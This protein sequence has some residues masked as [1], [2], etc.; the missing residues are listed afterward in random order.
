MT[1]TEPMTVAEWQRADRRA[2]ERQA[3][4]D[5]LRRLASLPL[6]SRLRVLATAQ[7]AVGDPE[8]DGV[9]PVWPKL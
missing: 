2:A 7:L 9:L 8:I 3:L 1:V 5:I 4:D 6:G